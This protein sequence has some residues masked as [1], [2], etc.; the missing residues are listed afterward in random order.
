MIKIPEQLADDYIRKQLKKGD[1]LYWKS[2]EGVEKTKNSYFVVLAPCIGEMLLAVRGTKRT[3]LYEGSSSVRPKFD[4]LKI[5]R[6]ETSIFDVDTMLDFKWIEEFSAND[7]KKVLGHKLTKLGSLP[8]A[9]VA[10][11]NNVVK[12][13]KTISKRHKAL[14]LGDLHGPIS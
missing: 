14:I 1:V 6:H 7:L 5:G 10:D 12:N 4:T 8:D 11:I 9:V 13:A 2:F 3:D